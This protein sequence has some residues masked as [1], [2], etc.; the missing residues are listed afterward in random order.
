LLAHAEKNLNK[1]LRR[2][3]RMS[4]K[5]F[6]LKTQLWSII[7]III[8]VV[9]GIEIL[10]LVQENQKLRRALSHPRGPFK[11]LGPGDKVHSLFGINLDGKEFKVDY[12]S[13]ER[14]MLLW[15]SPTCP[16][17]E[18]NLEFWKEIYRNYRS[19]NLRFI[20]VTN[21]GQDKTSEF[22][23]V[24]QLEFPILIVSNLSLME[25][26]KVEVIPQTILID[27]NGIVQK[28]W[29]GPLTDEY[30]KEI[31]FMISSPSEL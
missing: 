5:K 16:S 2:E 28:V 21:F 3:N 19:E 20:G 24:N 31:R 26:Y 17:C 14:T 10:L 29:P 1:I 18:E 4:E 8:V 9:M 6:S 22:A 15:F 13:K 27:T 23:K 7:L 12:P 30:K 11:V 25:Q